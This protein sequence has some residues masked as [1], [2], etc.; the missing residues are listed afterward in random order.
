S[1]WTV[2]SWPRTAPLQLPARRLPSSVTPDGSPASCTSTVARP[3]P[4]SSVAH[5]AAS[6]A[7]AAARWASPAHAAT[8]GGWL[9]PRAASTLPI[10]GKP[11]LSPRGS[12]SVSAGPAGGGGTAGGATACAGTPGSPVRIKPAQKYG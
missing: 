5:P 6:D 1:G 11:G 12:F 9:S 8:A 10:P 7:L 2:P 3:P 4:T